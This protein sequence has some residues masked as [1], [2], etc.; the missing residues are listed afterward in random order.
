MKHPLIIPEVPI[1]YSINGN[2]SWSFFLK[3]WDLQVLSS[4]PGT[5]KRSGIFCEKQRIHD[6]KEYSKGC[7]CNLILGC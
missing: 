7:G 3:N 6:I 1:K 5:T 4:N 2:K